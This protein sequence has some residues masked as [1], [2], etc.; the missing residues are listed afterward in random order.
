MPLDINP[1]PNNYFKKLR[2]VEKIQNS[3]VKLKK[4][5]V[6]KN[7]SDGYAKSIRQN[8]RAK[9]LKKKSRERKGNIFRTSITINKNEEFNYM[10]FFYS[11]LN[12]C[13]L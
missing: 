7:M 9:R 8:R 5:G 6:K 3:T 11:I 4:I 13:K 2:E 12:I 1:K 10:I